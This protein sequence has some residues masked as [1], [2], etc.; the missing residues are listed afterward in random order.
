MRAGT[1]IGGMSTVICN[2]GVNIVE[3]Y[4]GQRLLDTNCGGSVQTTIDCPAS[5]GTLATFSVTCNSCS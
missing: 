4:S 1:T 5:L 2:N 3:V